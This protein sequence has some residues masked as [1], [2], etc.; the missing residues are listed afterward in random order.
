M[1]QGFTTGPSATGWTLTAAKV[2]VHHDPALTGSY[3]VRICPES[4]GRP[5]SPCLGTLTPASSIPT[6]VRPPA[7]T[8][9]AP[10]TGIHLAA[11]TTY[12][13]VWDSSGASYKYSFGQASTHGEDA[14]ALPGWSIANQS[15]AGQYELGSW[16]FSAN[17]EG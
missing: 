11:N 13:V 1:A 16:P 6:S 17:P 2:S 7:S 9:P 10:D 15:V 8:F 3:S 12:F 14:G 5:S 4:A